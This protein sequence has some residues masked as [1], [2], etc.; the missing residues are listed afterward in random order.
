MLLL[1]TLGEDSKYHYPGS[2][3]DAKKIPK[4]FNVFP[5]FVYHNSHPAKTA[6]KIITGNEH[7]DCGIEINQIYNHI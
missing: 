1:Y 5:V 2:L 6:S 3:N 7:A 4:F